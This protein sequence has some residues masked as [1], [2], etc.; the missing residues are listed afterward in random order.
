LSKYTPTDGFSA[1]LPTGVRLRY[2]YYTIIIII[3]F[4]KPLIYL[5]YLTDTDTVK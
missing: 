5:K 4:R 1:I 3:I 2:R